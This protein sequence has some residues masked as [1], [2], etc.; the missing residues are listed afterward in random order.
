[1]GA[2]REA[3]ERSVVAVA[4]ARAARSRPLTFPPELPVLAAR[5]GHRR[6]DPRESG[7]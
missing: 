6:G 7:S 2:Y 3:I 5:R 1:M 4:R